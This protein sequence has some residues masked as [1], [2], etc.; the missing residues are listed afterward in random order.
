MAQTVNC[1]PTMW[2]TRV[3]SLGREDP[4]AKEISTHSSNLAWKIPWTEETGSFPNPG[5]HKESD[6]T[7]RL[8]FHFHLNYAHCIYLL[9][10]WSINWKIPMSMIWHF[11]FYV[12]RLNIL[13]LQNIL[14]TCL[15]IYIPGFSTLVSKCF[16][17][18]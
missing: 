17:L 8:N 14:C 5:G 12:H 16:M 2:Q 6:M 7:E 4:L 10:N 1:L 15:K 13:K 11:K 18:R 3:W 9:V